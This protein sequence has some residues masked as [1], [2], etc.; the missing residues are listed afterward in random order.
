MSNPEGMPFQPEISESKKEF[1]PNKKRKLSEVWASVVLGVD[2][3]NEQNIEGL[4]FVELRNLLNKQLLQ[5]TDALLEEWNIQTNE[6]VIEKMQQE[7]DKTKKAE[8]ELDYIK[9]IHEQIDKLVQGFNH[10]ESK[11]T[12]WDS[13]P[14]RMRDKK[15]GTRLV[16]PCYNGEYAYKI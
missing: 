2:V 4:T 12:K 13:W 15:E 3:M 9:Q 5:E 10:S 11:S 6:S 14:D 7:E 8:L 1:P 16:S